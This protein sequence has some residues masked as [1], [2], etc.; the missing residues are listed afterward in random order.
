MDYEYG[1]ADETVRAWKD[2]HKPECRDR[3]RGAFVYEKTMH[4]DFPSR[5][6]LFLLKLPGIDEVYVVPWKSCP[7]KPDII[8]A[9]D[10]PSW[11]F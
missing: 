5:T 2:E 8:K 9:S 1:S 4:N 3:E 11:E 10:R 7:G 6:D